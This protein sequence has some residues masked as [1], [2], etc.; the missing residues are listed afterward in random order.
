MTHGCTDAW[1]FSFLFFL[2]S[3]QILRS[4]VS[5]L[6]LHCLPKSFFFNI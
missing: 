2:L 5:E 6:A 3:V 4:V 1:T